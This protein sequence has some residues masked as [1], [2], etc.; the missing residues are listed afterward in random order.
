[1]A[2]G[3]GDTAAAAFAIG[4]SD[5]HQAFE[6]AGT[7]GVLTFLMDKPQ[8]NPLFMNR[9]H[10][11]P[12]LWIAHGANSMMGGAVDWL[13]KQIFTEFLDYTVL[14]DRVKG[15][16]P[17]AHGVVFLPYLAGER[18]PVWNPRAKAVWYGMTLE[19]SQLDLLESVFEAGAYSMRQIRD[20]GEQLLKVSIDSVIAVGNGTKSKHWCQMKSD[21]LGVTYTTTAF[22]DAAAYG[23]ALMGGIAANIF[24]GPT[25]AKELLENNLSRRLRRRYPIIPLAMELMPADIELFKLLL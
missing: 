14:D 1:M 23:A 12:G 21:V 17:G 5:A 9:C 3:S 11:I 10:V 20:Y 13:R 25:D 4:F 7:S 6:S 24:T 22:T 2:I 15:A 18:C 16:V 8:F 19:T